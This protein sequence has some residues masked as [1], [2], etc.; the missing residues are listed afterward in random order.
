MKQTEI[1]KLQG[2]LDAQTIKKKT[3]RLN[4]KE[5]KRAKSEQTNQ[6]LTA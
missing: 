3:R 4:Q 6:D 5:R 1:N 2:F